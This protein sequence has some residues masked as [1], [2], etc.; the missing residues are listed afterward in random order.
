ML[1]NWW[2]KWVGIQAAYFAGVDEGQNR[3]E[4]NA[5]LRTKETLKDLEWSERWYGSGPQQ[6]W[7]IRQGGEDIH[8]LGV[9]VS[10]QQVAEIVHRHNMNIRK[11]ADAACC[12]K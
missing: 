10:S 3:T 8:W 4:A 12:G 1:K 2:M 6:G 7:H 5:A 11:A 9:G